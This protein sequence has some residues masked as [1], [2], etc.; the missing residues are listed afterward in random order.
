MCDLKFKV[1]RKAVSVCD[2]KFKVHR[3]GLYA[4][5]RS[6]R[7]ALTNILTD[8]R[9][10]HLGQKYLIIFHGLGEGICWPLTI[11]I[12]LCDRRPRLT[13]YGRFLSG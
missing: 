9:V 2:L 4:I 6:N 1:H 8:L 5:R 7:V 3:K 13:H 11:R 10:A 12:P